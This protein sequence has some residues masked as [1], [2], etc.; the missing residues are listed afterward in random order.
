MSVVFFRKALADRKQE[1]LGSQTYGS[2]Q[3]SDTLT[4][5]KRTSFSV[6]TI[7]CRP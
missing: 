5:N 3:S 2:T 4:F 7:F 1:K 6:W